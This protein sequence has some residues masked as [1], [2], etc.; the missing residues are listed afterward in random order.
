MAK[1]RRSAVALVLTWIALAFGDRAGA[2]LPPVEITSCGLSVAF[3][4]AVLIAD[5][6]C[7]GAPSPT[8]TLEYS[9]LDLAGFTL[10]STVVCR[11]GCTV[12]S[13]LPGGS[14]VGSLRA[15]DANFDDRASLTIR[16]ATLSGTA[17]SDG[18]ISC[19]DA[20]IVG[21]LNASKTI[22]V[23]GSNVQGTVRGEG[24]VTVVDSSVRS[25]SGTSFLNGGLG[26]ITVRRSQVTSSGI[27]G[28]AVS[29][30]AV[31]SQIVATV[32]DAVHVSSAGLSSSI[33]LVRSHV[34]ASAGAGI[35][36]SG[37][38]NVRLSE[39]VIENSR[40]GVVST[41]SPAERRKVSLVRSSVIG[42]AL[43]GLR[44]DGRI[45]AQL[46]NVLGNGL[47]AQCGVTVEC[48][49]LHASTLPSIRVIPGSY[50][51]G[52]SHVLGSG[53]PGASWGVCLGD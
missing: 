52:T 40:R 4:R 38:G 43:D 35:S 33:S 37:R 22:S 20:E 23:R 41:G 44:V 48:A 19:E 27:G 2:A 6:D 15:R 31:D 47:D 8:L 26:K 5:L 12:T 11:E 49:D 34:T 46:S 1:T 14:L 42:N 18:S 13:S 24:R 16:G 28:S 10:T 53:I 9:T 30:S 29:V 36:L 32:S 21:S 50:E 7:T 51:C 39:T 25:V 45:Q 17:N 3:A